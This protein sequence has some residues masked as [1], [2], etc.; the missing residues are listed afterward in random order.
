MSHLNSQQL[1]YYPC[2]K[3]PQ[4]SLSATIKLCSLLR[5]VCIIWDLADRRWAQLDLPLSCEF[6][7]LRQL[8]RS[9]IFLGPEAT[10]GKRWESKRATNH[11]NSFQSLCPRHI[12]W[13]PKRKGIAITWPDQS[14]RQGVHSSHSD[15]ITLLWMNHCVL[16]KSIIGT[17]NL[18]YFSHIH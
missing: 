13:E 1:S 9:V 10:C 14:Q 2:N 15:A 12:H 8:H 7:Y 18:I 4:N 3:L 11:T 16:K 17:G 6:H 5:H